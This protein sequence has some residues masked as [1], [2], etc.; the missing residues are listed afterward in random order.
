M[1]A[2]ASRMMPYAPA[3]SALAEIDVSIR[4]LCASYAR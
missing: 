1:P 2:M 3:Q 4:K